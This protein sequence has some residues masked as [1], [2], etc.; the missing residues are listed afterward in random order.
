M[1]S[2][3]LLAKSIWLIHMRRLNPSGRNLARTIVP[4]LKQWYNFEE[5][6]SFDVNDP[7]GVEFKGGEFAT[8][9]NRKI[10]VV[11]T[12]YND[13]VVVQAATSTDD[14]D[15]FI[16]L[17]A[18]RL[19]DEGLIEY[20][21]DMVWRKQYSSEIEIRADSDLLLLSRFERFCNALT[22]A[23]Y[24]AKAGSSVGLVGLLFDIDLTISGKQIPFKF[25]RRQGFP[26]SENLFYSHGPLTTKKHLE[27]LELLESSLK[28]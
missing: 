22:E 9:D 16:E 10:G 28:S 11:L 8:P 4:M 27:L 21:P 25:E 3:V 20:A 26:F 7:K 13:G 6:K 19:A 24:P 5:P 17:A 12:V 18:K 14:A 15:I 23:V 2:Q 1:K